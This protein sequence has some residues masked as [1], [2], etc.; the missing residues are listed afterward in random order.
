MSQD[1]QEV[2]WATHSLLAL[3]DMPNSNPYNILSILIFCKI[4]GEKNLSYEKRLSCEEKPANEN[5]LSCD[6]SYLGIKVILW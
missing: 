4:P 6:K 5:K 2:M 1:T 3:F